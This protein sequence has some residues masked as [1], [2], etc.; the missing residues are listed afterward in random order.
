MVSTILP[1]RCSSKPRLTAEQLRDAGLASSAAKATFDGLHP[2][3]LGHLCRQGQ[4]A[5]AI[6]WEA[7]E[8]SSLVPPQVHDVSAPLIP[9][10]NGNL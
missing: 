9:K 3:H 2:R 8:L 5:A 1:R 6:L 7:C 4:E 10:K